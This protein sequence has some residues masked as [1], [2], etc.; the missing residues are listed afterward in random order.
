MNSM[1]HLR[2]ADL[3]ANTPVDREAHL[4]AA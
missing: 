2:I 4:D 3:L 1:S